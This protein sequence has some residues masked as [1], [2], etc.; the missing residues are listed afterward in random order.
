MGWIAENVESIKS[1]KIRDT[2]SQLITLGMIVSMALIIWKALMCL[3]G[4]E[5]PVVVVLSGSMEPA[6]K[7]GDI[8]FL[9]M[10]EAPFRAG[11]I[12]VYN[13][14]GEPIP[15]VH[16]V[17]ELRISVTAD[18]LSFVGERKA[19]QQ[20]VHEQEN[21]GK[22]DILTKGDAND[23]D[24]R[25]LYAYGQYWLKPQQIMGRAVGFMPYAGWV[26]IMMTEKP[27]IKYVL[28]GALG[29]LVIT[30]KD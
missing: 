25:G 15:I 24:D 30:S 26:T 4:S 7:R 20:A 29:L 22:V 28:I 11:E 13:V 6:F 19:D 12:V 1:M 27:I 2:L 8:L 16:R 18:L 23:V 10:S 21:T 17:V 3:T 14:E 9:H 5:S